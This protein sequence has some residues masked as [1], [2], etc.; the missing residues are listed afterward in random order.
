MTDDVIIIVRLYY[1]YIV[2]YTRDN[3]M[4]AVY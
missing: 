1:V 4:Y 3:I 2:P